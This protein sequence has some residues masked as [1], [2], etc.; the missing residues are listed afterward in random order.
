MTLFVCEFCRPD[1]EAG[2]QDF[3]ER[4]TNYEKVSMLCELYYVLVV[5][6]L[7]SKV[8]ELSELFNIEPSSIPLA[9][10]RASAGRLI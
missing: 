10:L 4:L 8:L 3:L 6:V 7:S 2:L 1:Y 5:H 9:G